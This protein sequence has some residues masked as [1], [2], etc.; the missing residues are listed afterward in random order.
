MC[1]MQ[2]FAVC[3][4]EHASRQGILIRHDNRAGYNHN[5][6]R[7][8]DAWEQNYE[9]EAALRL[10]ALALVLGAATCTKGPNE[11][12]RLSCPVMKRT[13]ASASCWMSFPVRFTPTKRYQTAPLPWNQFTVRCSLVLVAKRPLSEL[14]WATAA[15]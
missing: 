3:S 7:W 4:G 14:P 5:M 15:I 1:V 11:M 9:T 6:A 8:S 13:A 10:P 12:S 2:Q